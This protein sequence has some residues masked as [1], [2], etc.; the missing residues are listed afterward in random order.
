M[1]REPIPPP[2]P[3]RVL[4]VADRPGWCFSTR[5]HALKTWAP[6]DISIDVVHY[7]HSGTIDHPFPC[8][9]VVFVMPPKKAREI[10][11]VCRRAGNQAPPLLCAWNSGPGRVGYDVFDVA[12]DCDFV[13]CNNW[14]SWA[15]AIS[16]TVGNFRGCHISNGVDTSFY[17]PTVRMA[18]RPEKVLWIAS[19]DKAEDAGDV[20]GWQT[21]AQPLAKILG[22]LG[23]EIDFRVVDGDSEL[24]ATEMRD[25]Y[26]TGSVLLITSITEGT[27][28]VGLEAAACGCAVVTSRVGNMPELIRNHES[29][30]LV[31]RLSTPPTSQFLQAVRFALEHRERLGP[32]ARKAVES[33]DWQD[34]CNWY[35]GV[36]RAAAAGRIHD[37]KPFSYLSVPWAE[38]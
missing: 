33:W 1:P 36:F 22:N 25:W 35:Y 24:S 37:L 15:M 10:R 32:A 8:Y 21:V 11:R 13:I 9:D 12:D 23:I 19:A 2:R 4:I 6:A 31:E 29:G 38:L 28:N 7:G 3:V 20:K 30:V 5:A 17:V 34:R 18:D 16:R 26:N 14:Q 27:P